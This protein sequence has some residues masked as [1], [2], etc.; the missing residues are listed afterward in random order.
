MILR[1]V[2]IG[3][4]QFATLSS[5]RAAQLIRGCP[6]RVDSGEHKPIMTAQ[7]EVAQGKVTQYVEVAEPVVAVGDVQPPSLDPDPALA[8]A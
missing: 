6:A 4:F 7:M 1:P 2:R 5:L 8:P 3:R